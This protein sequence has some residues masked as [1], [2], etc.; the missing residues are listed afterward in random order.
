MPAMCSLYQ[1]CQSTQ[2][3][4]RRK[5]RRGAKNAEFFEKDFSASSAPLRS[6]RFVRTLKDL[7]RAWLAP[8]ALILEEMR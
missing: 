3:T 2:R 1:Q 4:Q 5:E 6:P 7:L 8:A